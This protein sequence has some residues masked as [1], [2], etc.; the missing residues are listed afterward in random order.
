[1]TGEDTV[2]LERLQKERQ[3]VWKV[4]LK[5]LSSPE[6]KIPACRDPS[7]TRR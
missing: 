1:M 5:T 2:N 3:Q 7:L 6:G 4:G